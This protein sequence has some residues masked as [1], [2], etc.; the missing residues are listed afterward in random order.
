MRKLIHVPVQTWRGRDPNDLV[1]GWICFEQIQNPDRGNG[2]SP[3]SMLNTTL[4]GSPSTT[5]YQD[6]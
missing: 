4:L 6:Y 1:G 2:P 3:G 5:A